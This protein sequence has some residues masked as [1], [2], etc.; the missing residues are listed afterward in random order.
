MKNFKVSKV[1]AAGTTSSRDEAQN[2]N[3]IEKAIQQF[4]ASSCDDLEIKKLIS[5]CDSKELPASR[6]FWI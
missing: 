6:I 4:L 5:A 3:E 1:L 2:T